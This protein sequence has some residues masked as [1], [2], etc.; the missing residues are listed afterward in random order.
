[1]TGK[2]GRRLDQRRYVRVTGTR[3]EQFVEFDF[4]IGDPALAVELVLPFAAFC[5][6][7]EQNEV[8]MV[9]PEEGARL[10]LEKIKWRYGDI[11]NRRGTRS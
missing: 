6:F 3:R 2:P 7:C 5:E 11:G 9:S 10:D 8:E 1:M 4:A